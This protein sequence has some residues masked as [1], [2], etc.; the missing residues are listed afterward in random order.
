MR[1]AVASLA[2]LADAAGWMRYCRGVGLWRVMIALTRLVPEESWDS[3]SI[4]RGGG[5]VVL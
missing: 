1:D 4:W 3:L 2:S 5:S